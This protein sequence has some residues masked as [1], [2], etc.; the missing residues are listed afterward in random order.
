MAGYGNRRPGRFTMALQRFMMGRYGTDKLNMMLLCVG[1]IVT[2]VNL[3]IHLDWLNL[4][5]ML[6]CAC[7][8]S[9][10]LVSK[11]T[12]PIELLMYT[13]SFIVMNVLLSL[14]VLFKY[15]TDLTGR[16][17][18]FM[19]LDQIGCTDEDSAAIRRGEVIGFYGFI[20]LIGLLYLVNIIAVGHMNHDMSAGFTAVFLIGFAVPL[21][22]CAFFSITSVFLALCRA[23]RRQAF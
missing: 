19:T 15:S 10:S 14:A 13:M 6:G 5:L 8:L 17:R 20:T 9:T 18:Y 4:L 2:V 12:K 3:F 16:T 7:L 21:V 1:L 11:Q 23:M 22:L